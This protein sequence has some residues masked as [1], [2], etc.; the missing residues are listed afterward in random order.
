MKKIFLIMM[1]TMLVFT[2]C[3]NKQG[4]TPGNSDSRED[5]KVTESA[6]NQNSEND[7]DEK[8]DAKEHDFDVA[9]LAD[10][11]FNGLEFEDELV[12]GRDIVFLNQYGLEE[13]DIVKQ[14]SYFSSNATTEEI[15]VV[16]CV[17]DAQAKVVKEAVDARVEER[18]EIFADYAP[19]EVKR[20]EGAIVKVLGK[21]VVLCVTADPDGA[22]AI[23]EKY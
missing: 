7:S 18:K 11:L 2:A 23:I 17:D 12:S 8:E 21:Y 13:G 3:G 4:D 5:N 9:V 20:L 14:A 6:G 19:D 15:A 1:M 10:E 16:E 22:E